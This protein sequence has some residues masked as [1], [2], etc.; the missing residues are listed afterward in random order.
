MNL[1]KVLSPL[2]EKEFR[3]WARDN[4]QLNSPISGI[5]HPVVQD[6]CVRMNAGKSGKTWVVKFSAGEWQNEFG[7]LEGKVGD[8]Y[9]VR[10]DKNKSILL[11][12]KENEFEII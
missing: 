9:N 12:L 11:A 7:V 6:E 1:F 4:Y 3:Q 8:F 10:P 2:E 5:W